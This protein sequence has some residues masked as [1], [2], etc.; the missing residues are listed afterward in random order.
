MCQ[1]TCWLLIICSLTFIILNDMGKKLPNYFLIG[2]LEVFLKRCSCR[3]LRFFSN[4]TISCTTIVRLPSGLLWVV[5][6]GLSNSIVWEMI[7][8]HNYFT[9]RKALIQKIVFS[10]TSQVLQKGSYN[11]NIIYHK[12]FWSQIIFPLMSFILYKRSKKWPKSFVTVKM[13]CFKKIVTNDLLIFTELKL[14]LAQKLSKVLGGS[15]GLFRKVS[16]FL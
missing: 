5:T 1:K 9:G 7:G 16:C 11:F 13:A 10:V 15:Y 6:W 2:I 14:Y 8:L 3:P 12:F 4:D